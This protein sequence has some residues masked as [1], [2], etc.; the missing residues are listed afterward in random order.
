MDRGTAVIALDYQH[1]VH[2]QGW[3]HCGMMSRSCGQS[4]GRSSSSDE[5]VTQ[6]PNSEAQKA[7]G[8]AQLN[9]QQKPASMGTP[10]TSWVCTKGPGWT[11][12]GACCFIGKVFGPPQRIKHWSGAKL[13]GVGLVSIKHWSNRSISDSGLLPSLSSKEIRAQSGSA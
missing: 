10:H 13:S 7:A 11:A 8:A 6:D 12:S 3:K 2:Q 4:A 5:G 9:I 1:G